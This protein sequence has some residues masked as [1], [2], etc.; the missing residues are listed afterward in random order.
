MY[1]DLQRDHHREADEAHFRWQTQ[2]PYFSETEARLVAEVA[3]AGERVLE[4]GC[5]HGGNLHHLGPGIER[6]GVDFSEQRASFA[7]RTGARCV[8][9]G[10]ERLPFADGTFDVV[11]VRD[12]L[13]HL[14]VRQLALD[15]AFR[16]LA[17][18]GRL[19]LIEPNVVA[20]FV[21]LQAMLIPTERGLL[22][23]TEARLRREV[24]AA[25]FEV[26]RSERL[27]PLPISRVLLH[28]H[29]GLPSLG[30]MPWMRRLLESAE[31]G[32]ARLLP[33]SSW[34]YVRLDCR[35]P[36]GARSQA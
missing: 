23:S 21:F 15:E 34:M 32:A 14:P 26:E 13:H 7:R 31:R 8:V 36:P 16:V 11:L 6:V 1:A 3:R 35:R 29:H 24:Q 25:G 33:R 27:Q 20:P 5:G 2:T 4:I 12:L 10:A 28:P 17:V 9:A 30:A 19:T 18:G 22:R